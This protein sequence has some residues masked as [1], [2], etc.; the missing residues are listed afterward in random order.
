[1]L[2]SHGYFHSHSTVLYHLCMKFLLLFYFLFAIFLNYFL[3]DKNGSEF[4]TFDIF[5]MIFFQTQLLRLK[6]VFAIFFLNYS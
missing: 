1:M 5:H 2:H 6:N 4:V 3:L